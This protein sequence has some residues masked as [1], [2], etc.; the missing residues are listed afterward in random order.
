MFVLLKEATCFPLF[1][2]MSFNVRYFFGFTRCREREAC[3]IADGN[4]V[5]LL[6]W[7]FYGF[8]VQQ[9]TV[10]EGKQWNDLLEAGI[11][12]KAIEIFRNFLSIHSKEWK[13]QV[14]RHIP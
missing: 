9:L 5:S 8:V 14:K 2:L 13:L 6:F 11:A 3:L 12:K 4:C 1:V 7:L 10:F